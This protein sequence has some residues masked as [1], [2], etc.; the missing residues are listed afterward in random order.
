MIKLSE[1]ISE[2]EVIK[3]KIPKVKN[4]DKICFLI[5]HSKQI[6]SRG[7][8]DIPLNALAEVI[9]ISKIK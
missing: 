5:K 2:L 9:G 4:Y 6:L 7:D 1:F 8:I 3:A